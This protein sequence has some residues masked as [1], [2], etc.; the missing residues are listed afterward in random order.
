MGAGAAGGVNPANL[1]GAQAFG[2]GAGSAAGGLGAG[3]PMN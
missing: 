2:A 1:L 3:N